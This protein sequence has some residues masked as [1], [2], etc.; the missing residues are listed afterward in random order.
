MKN[1]TYKS[2]A[3]LMI[4]SILVGMVYVLSPFPSKDSIS[5]VNNNEFYLPVYNDFELQIGNSC[6]A[7]SA[8][9][10]LRNLGIPSKGADVYAEIPYKDPFLGYVFTKGLVLYLQT[11]GIT[12]M[13]Y[14]GD[15]STLKARLIQGNSP[16]IVLI[17]EGVNWQHFITLLG[18]NNDKSELYFFDS[19]EV[20]DKN[21]ELPGNTT[22]ET[23]IFLN[24]WNNGLPVFNRIYIATR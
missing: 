14:K 9:Y 10:I 16:I 24:L 19:N 12:S 15:L 2:I 3:L 8:A 23:D 21:A 17:G 4:L 7:Y 1:H 22:I 6:A 11:Q 18:F 5:E 13:I 20:I